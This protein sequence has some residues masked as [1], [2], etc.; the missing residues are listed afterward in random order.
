MAAK[1]MDE[2]SSPPKKERIVSPEGFK[3]KDSRP[4]RKESFGSQKDFLSVTGKEVEDKGLSHGLI[5]Q[6]VKS[7]PKQQLPEPSIDL[8]AEPTFPLKR[9][10]KKKKN[11]NK[12][13]P[14]KKT[15]ECSSGMLSSDR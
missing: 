3:D 9:K 8:G 11:R 6:D 10:K 2:V 15:E 4:P 5:C 14:L 1:D 7:G 13:R 12:D